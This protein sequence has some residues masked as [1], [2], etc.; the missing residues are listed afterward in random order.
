V[1][2]FVARRLLQSALLLFAV[3]TASF[4]LLH[5]APGGPETALLEN[6]KLSPE[7]VERYRERFG[8]NDPLPIRYVKWLRNVV[9]LDFGQSYAYQ[10]PV[11][12]VIASRAWP[13]LQLGILS[14]AIGLL[15]VPLGVY[16]ARRRG[17]FGDNAVR[18]MTVIGSAVPTWWLALGAIVVMSSAIGWFPNG[19]GDEGPWDWFRHVIVPAMLLGLGGVISFTRFVRSSV[20]EELGQDYVRTA[21]AKGLTESAINRAHVLRN[22]FIPVVTLLGY[23][24]PALLSGAVI[25]EFIFNWPGMGKLFYEAALGRDYPVL[26]GMLLLGT[27]LTIL[28]TLLADI[29]YGIVDP[30]IRYT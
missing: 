3:M 6:P 26:L 4:F 28:G 23:L 7:T 2:A 20:L 19:Q 8:L 15:G 18:L 1:G 9:L 22:A 11:T 30:R 14:Y 21:R 5:A 10:R 17:R 16:A 24:L 13:T 27:A 12:D 25:T 29:G